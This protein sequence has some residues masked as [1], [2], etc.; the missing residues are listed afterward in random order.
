MTKRLSVLLCLVLL[1]SLAACRAEAPA[2][3][4]PAT[5][6]TQTEAAT[7]PPETEPAELTLEQFLTKAGGIWVLEDSIFPLNDNE[8]CY[9]FIS[10]GEEGYGGGVYPGEG[11][12][13][14]KFEGFRQLSEDR[15]RLE[16]V[17]EAGEFMGETLEEAHEVL[18]F[19]LE[20]DG[21]AQLQID[22]FEAFTCFYGGSDLDSAQAAAREYATE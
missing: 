20:V 18:T 8:Y 9:T 4:E 11:F 17:Y 10:L 7:Q 2:P 5:R 6:P 14:A 21:T 22:G 16:L 19:T 13:P 12:R 1:L 15:F 3:T